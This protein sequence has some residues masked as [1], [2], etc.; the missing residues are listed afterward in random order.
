MH[1]LRPLTGLDVIGPAEFV[2]TELR[3]TNL[4]NVII[5]TVDQFT[6]FRSASGEVKLAS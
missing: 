1:K 3:R 5:L 4:P 2:I 6:N